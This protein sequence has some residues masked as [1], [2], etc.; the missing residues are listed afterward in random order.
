M[1]RFDFLLRFDLLLRYELLLRFDLLLRFEL[2]LRFDLLFCG[3]M[4][5]QPLSG[6]SECFPR[7]RWSTNMRLPMR[8]MPKTSGITGLFTMPATI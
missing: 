1:L 2:M 3:K 7:I 5:D 6:I 4:R 8:I